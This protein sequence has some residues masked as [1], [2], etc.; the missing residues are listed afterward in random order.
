MTRPDSVAK[1]W[2]V[3]LSGLLTAIVIAV[4]MR[5]PI[6]GYSFG[7]AVVAASLWT[8]T[9]V[10]AGTL[11]F[12]AAEGVVA[13]RPTWPPLRLVVGSAATWA[14]IPA[15]LIC[16]LRG[17]GWAAAMSVVAGATMAAGSWSM[18]LH[19]EAVEDWERWAEGPLFADL[20]APDSGQ[21]QAFAIAVCVELAIVLVS[22]GAV[23]LATAL[24]G[25]AGFLFVWKRLA[26]L[27]AKARDGMARPAARASAAAVLAL[28]ILIP[29]LLA[30]FA[31]TTGAVETRA[32][33]AVRTRAEGENGTAADPYQGIVLFTVQE[34]KKEL[35]PLPVRRDLLRTG[36]AK[37]LVIPFDGSYWYFQAPEHGPGIHPHLAHGDPVA[38]SIYSTGWVP[39]AMQAHQTLAQPVDLR[40]AGA[41]QVTVRN[42]DNRMGRIDMGVL[43]T[44][45]TAPGKPSM[46]LGTE[47]ILSTEA[48]HFAFKS[49]PVTDVIRYAIPERRAIGKFDGITVLFFPDAT[50]ATLGARVGIQQFELMPR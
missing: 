3:S 43:L 4:W 15:I 36:M 14:L 46:Y 41:L 44:D 24:M 48:D 29:L 17:S 27:N 9:T 50:R 11:G 45:S 20:P 12:C 35:P 13:G 32:Q 34:K 25:I 21:P 28:L 18:T 19:A 8:L 37:P 42:G 30:R 38:V 49:N 7:K 26:T 22:R 47:P 39:L 1:P 31:R 5:P 10:L 16:W 40:P 23:F 2:V 6:P 33:A